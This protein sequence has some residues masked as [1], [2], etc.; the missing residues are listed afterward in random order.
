[1]TLSASF[2]ED[3]I[4]L[5]V[6]PVS[7]GVLGRVLGRRRNVSLDDLSEKDWDLA[8]ALADLKAAADESGEGLRIASSSIFLSH[9]L[10]ARLDSRTAS[11]L[12]LPPVVHLVLR[13]DVEGLIGTSSFR[14]RYEWIKDGRRQTPRRVGAILMT[15]EGNRRIPAWLLQAV[16]VADS[17][18]IG[19]DD[20]AQ[21]EV[22]AK[23]RNALDPGVRLVADDEMARVSL[24]DF[25]QGLEVRLADGF[26]IAPRETPSGLDFEIVP[27]SGKAIET[28]A[29]AGEPVREEHA[30][31]AGGEI[32]VFQERVRSRGALPAYK[33]GDG[34][35]LVIDRSAMP[36]LRVIARMQRASPEERAAFI[37]N[38]R[39]AIAREVEAAL[40]ASGKLDGLTDSGLEEAIENAAGP[41][42]VETR[43]FSER[44]VGVGFFEK[45]NLE[46]SE[47]KPTTWLPELFEE[48][49]ASF[50]Q[51]LD[52]PALEALAHEIETA[53]SAGRSSIEV[54]GHAVPATPA[55]LQAVRWERDARSE[56][57][58]GTEND[59]GD[60]QGRRPVILK[61]E[62]NFSVL[63]WRPN[64]SGRQPKVPLSLPAGI[65]T[66]LMDHQV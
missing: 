46:G 24:T 38:P 10:A 21:W 58:S 59:S 7:R 28:L 15:A 1:M 36:A 37:R 62:D 41:L 14:L 49:V 57:A 5:A 11:I 16:E 9:L 64:P 17:F 48:S 34:K 22:L 30:E 60:E 27:F 52:T 44:V 6:D 3:G 56:P 45:P 20:A 23:F 2:N 19:R 8:F 4:S 63:R 40:R 32:A 35:Y 26:S 61:T 39:P 31:L 53:I 13:T 54:S 25:M 18:E 65:R 29:E 33:V 42:F 47:H 66:R 51:T 43:E 12:G 55:T 50:I